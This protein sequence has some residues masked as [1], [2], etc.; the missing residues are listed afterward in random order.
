[1]NEVKQVESWLSN[2]A[3]LLLFLDAQRDNPDIDQRYY[4]KAV[5]VMCTNMPTV[6]LD[7]V[8]RFL[9]SDDGRV[10]R[11]TMKFESIV[12]PYTPEDMEKAG[13]KNQGLGE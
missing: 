4:A 11:D 1:M 5:E 7:A 12:N 3:L 8:E 6:L 10:W 2:V 9:D 13:K